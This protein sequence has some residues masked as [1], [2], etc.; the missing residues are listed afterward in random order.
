MEIRE[1]RF[2]RRKWSSNTVDNLV[3]VR[4]KMAREF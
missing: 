2:S 3:K 4:T 1:A